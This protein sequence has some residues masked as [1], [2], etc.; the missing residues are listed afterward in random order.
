[1]R[2]ILVAAA[3][4]LVAPLAFA[5]QSIRLGDIPGSDGN[6]QYGETIVEAPADLVQRWFSE[7]DLWSRRF[8]DTEWAQPLGTDAQGRKVV[9]FRSR[10]IGRPLTLHLTESRGLIAYD[11]E[12]KGITT[13]GKIFVQPLGPRRTRVIMQSSSQVHG[14][15]G[16]FASK[17]V[18][19]DRAFKKFRADLS[20][21]IG[22]SNAWAAANRRGG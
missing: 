12:G 15:A 1:M 10:V 2:A 9:K 14:A 5:Q 3:L 18:R 20:A 8:P 22:M 17:K 13:Q 16:I 21:V 4:T 7:A 6:W 19:R 11:G